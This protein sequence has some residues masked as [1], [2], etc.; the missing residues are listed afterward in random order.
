MTRNP[1]I[2]NT[3]V[4]VLSN[5]C[6]FGQVRDTKFDM[7]VSNKTLQYVTKCQ[8]PNF[9]CFWVIKGTSSVK[10]SDPGHF[11]RAHGKFFLLFLYAFTYFWQLK[12]T[13]RAFKKFPRSLHFTQL[14]FLQYLNNY[15]GQT[16]LKHILNNYLGQLILNQYIISK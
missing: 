9:Y 14:S 11:F 2:G 6:R 8:G 10:R 3:P 1:E 7:D 4:R 5:I 16:N 15:L 13:N 12:I